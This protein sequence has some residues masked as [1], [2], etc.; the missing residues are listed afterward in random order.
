[1]LT[2]NVQCPWVFLWYSIALR[3]L[4]L[5]ADIS[6]DVGFQLNKE[7]RQT[8]PRRFRKTLVRKCCVA[9][10]HRTTATTGR[11]Q[12]VTCYG[13]VIRTVFLFPSTYIISRIVLNV[14]FY[15]VDSYFSLPVI[16]SHL[17]KLLIKMNCVNLLSK[18]FTYIL[19][20]CVFVRMFGK[21]YN[22]HMNTVYSHIKPNKLNLWVL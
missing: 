7:L 18:T 14:R 16:S 1:M 17:V 10:R 2:V 6:I 8:T 4:H 12:N 19:S 20:L 22:L 13:S 11:F 21:T 5:F 15:E 9:T 3:Y